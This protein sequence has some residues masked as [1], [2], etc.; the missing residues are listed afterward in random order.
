MKFRYQYFIRRNRQLI[1]FSLALMLALFPLKVFSKQNTNVST[2]K[3]VIQITERNI[4]D[5]EQYDILREADE[6]YKKNDFQAARELYETVKISIRKEPELVK[7]PIYETDV[8]K[9]SGAMKV[10]WRSALDGFEKDNYAPIFVSLRLLTRNYPEFIPAYFKLVEACKMYQEACISENYAKD[11]DPRT[12]INILEQ[13]TTL[14]PYDPDLLKAK[15]EALDEVKNYLGASIAARQ[16]SIIYQ[17]E[18]EASEFKALADKYL[19]KYKRRVKRQV[20][21]SSIVSGLFN[22]S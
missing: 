16:F 2:K 19:K 18:E 6:L 4:A 10:Y 7:E 13:A 3:S 17:D 15:I 8:Q 9:L 5:Q 21:G 11:D 14:Y 12:I 1:A 20:I 22:R